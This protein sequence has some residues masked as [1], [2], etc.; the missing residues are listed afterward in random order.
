MGFY[1]IEQHKVV[2]NCDVEVK[3]CMIF[4]HLKKKKTEKCGVQKYSPPLYSSEVT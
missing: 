1:V 2:H 3:W 4:K